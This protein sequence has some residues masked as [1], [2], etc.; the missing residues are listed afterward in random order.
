[1]IEEIIEVGNKEKHIILFLQFVVVVEML[2]RHPGEE[3]QH[4]Y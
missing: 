2:E 3:K 4:R 1:M